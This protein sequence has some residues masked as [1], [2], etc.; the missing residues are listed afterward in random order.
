MASLYIVATP[1]GNLKDITLRAIE[2][3][4]GVD[5]ILCED[6]RTTKK[7]L[8]A[9]GISTRTASYNSKS[10]TAKKE[11]IFSLLEEGKD[12]A[13]VSDA[14]TPCISDP[15]V[16][17]VSQVKAHFGET[18]SIVPIP[19]ASA[20]VTALSASGI[21]SSEFTFL[22][23][24]PHK[25]GRETL[26]KEIAASSR[27]VALYESPHRIEKTLVSLVEHLGLERQVVV[28]RELTKMFEQFVSGTPAEVKK[29]FETHPDKVRGE[30]VVVIG[31]KQ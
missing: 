23:F 29:Y 18:V 25:K 17:I 21:P 10:T 11:Y 30:F 19:G 2:V 31:G 12:I 14:G 24:L 28:G 13:L 8:D 5:V 6:T 7:L 27:A 22:G 26:F 3:L 15:G 20:L 1:I 16:L 4:G 9:H